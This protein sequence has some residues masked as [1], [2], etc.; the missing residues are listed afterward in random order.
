MPNVGQRG[1]RPGGGVKHVDR[2]AASI[3]PFSLPCLL[4]VEV[5]IPLPV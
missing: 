2:E 4:K 1:S 5:N 3:A